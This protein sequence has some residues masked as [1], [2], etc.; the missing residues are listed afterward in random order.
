MKKVTKFS[1]VVQQDVFVVMDSLDVSLNHA[2]WMVLPAMHLV[3]HIIV[4]LI[5]VHLIFK[6]LVNM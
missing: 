5:C 6:E 2:Y 3:I 1:Q 4:L